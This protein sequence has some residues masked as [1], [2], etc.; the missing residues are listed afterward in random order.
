MRVVITPRI[1]HTARPT[2]TYITTRA[3]HHTLRK[4]VWRSIRSA[5]LQ[6]FEERGYGNVTIEQISAAANVSRATFFN[7]FASDR[8]VG[9]PAGRPAHQPV[10]PT[11]PSSS[12]SAAS[13]SLA[14]AARACPANATARSTR[15]VTVT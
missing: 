10:Q 2:T 1:R 3:T 12:A 6:L 8:R 9:G 13:R 5:A 15:A 14:S 7:Y 11:S 4:A